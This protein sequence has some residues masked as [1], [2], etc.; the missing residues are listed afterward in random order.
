MMDG[1]F[2]WDIPLIRYD[3]VDGNLY[4]LKKD[5]KNILHDRDRHNRKTCI[6]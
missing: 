3:A 2:V 1:A 4:E 6:L 5:S